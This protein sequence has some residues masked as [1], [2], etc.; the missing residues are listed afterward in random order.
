VSNESKYS[1]A[2]GQAASRKRLI[3]EDNRGGLA[4]GQ[5]LHGPQS[6]L[7]ISRSERVIAII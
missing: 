3:G 6:G 7:W 1:F 2:C 5:Q 4:P